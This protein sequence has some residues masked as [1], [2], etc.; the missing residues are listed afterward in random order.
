MRFLLAIVLPIVAAVGCHYLLRNMEGAV[1]LSI[2]S[3]VLH[4][5]A[6]IMVSGAVA[7]LLAVLLSRRQKY[8]E[9]GLAAFCGVTAVVAVNFLLVG[10]GILLMLKGAPAPKV[11]AVHAAATGIASAALASLFVSS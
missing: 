11:L 1:P 9:V 8:P 10:W 7:G 6:V 3:V 4:P 5:L 2:V